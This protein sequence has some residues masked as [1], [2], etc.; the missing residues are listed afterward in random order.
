MAQRI[1]SKEGRFLEFQSAASSWREETAGQ[2]F[3]QI[4]KTTM[5]RTCHRLDSNSHHAT[6]M[7]AESEKARWGVEVGVDFCRRTRGPDS[8]KILFFLTSLL[9]TGDTTTKPW[10]VGIRTPRLP[11][12]TPPHTHTSPAIPRFS[13]L[14]LPK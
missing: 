12:E 13:L 10:N 9:P 11:Q 2:G 1:V 6:C 3:L 14:F 7:K 4:F 8:T 5:K